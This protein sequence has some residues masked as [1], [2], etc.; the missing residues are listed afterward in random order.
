MRFYSYNY[1]LEQIAKFDWW[2]AAFTLFLII[3]LIF[4]F[5][6]RVISGDNGQNYL[7]EKIDLENPKVELIEVN[8]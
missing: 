7:L 8:K 3:C 6:F 1:L 2:G 4:T 5:Y